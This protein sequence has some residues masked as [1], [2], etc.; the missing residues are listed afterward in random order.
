MRFRLKALGAAF[1]AAGWRPWLAGVALVAFV[2]AQATCFVHCHL[3]N[4]RGGT[5]T[6]PSP[7]SC[8]SRCAA[9]CHRNATGSSPAKHDSMPVSACSTLM[10]VASDSVPLTVVAPDL[11]VL[12]VLQPSAL[13]LLSNA[14]VPRAFF[15]R[16]AGP[17]DWILTPEVSLGPALRTLAPPLFPG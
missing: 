13:S 9:H 1:A 6:S 10:Q 7:S 14:L 8:Q 11:P 3:A 4:A 5:A 16:A 12:Y 17:D 2:A 15:S